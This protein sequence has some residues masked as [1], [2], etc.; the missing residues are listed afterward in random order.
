MKPRIKSKRLLQ[1]QRISSGGFGADEDEI[2]TEGRYSAWDEQELVL[3]QQ[4]ISKRLLT[5]AGNAG[6]QPVWVGNSRRLNNV[7][8]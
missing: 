6:P 1:P 5:G 4:F 2:P 3:G 8:M 7:N